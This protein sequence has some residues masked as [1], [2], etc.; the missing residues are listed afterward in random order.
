MGSLKIKSVDINILGRSS[1]ASSVQQ[2]VS[3]TQHQ[4]TTRTNPTASG[5]FSRPPA[6]KVVITTI[7]SFDGLLLNFSIRQITSTESTTKMI[8]DANISVAGAGQPVQIKT[9]N[10]RYS[11]LN[12]SMYS[13]FQ[14]TIG[15]KTSSLLLLDLEFFPALRCFIIQPKNL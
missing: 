6:E 15:L 3:P 5:Q 9:H 14:R 8:T 7:L 1:Q 11:I 13:D 12:F 4:H 10:K 2:P